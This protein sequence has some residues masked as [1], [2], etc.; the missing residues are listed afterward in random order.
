MPSKVCSQQTD[1]VINSVLISSLRASGGILFSGAYTGARVQSI[2]TNRKGERVCGLL[3]DRKDCVRKMLETLRP[4]TVNSYGT[5]CVSYTTKTSSSPSNARFA[6][7]GCLQ[8]N[9]PRTP[10]DTDNQ[11]FHLQNFIVGMIEN[12][13]SR[14]SNVLIAYASF[15][16]A[17]GHWADYM[18]NSCRGP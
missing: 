17:K 10:L 15:F 2:M 11:H 1:Q 18:K 8:K 14:F 3:I 7:T 12:D 13:K 9:W 5:F 16:P 4:S 6:G